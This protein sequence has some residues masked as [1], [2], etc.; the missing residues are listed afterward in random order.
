MNS[1]E[2]LISLYLT[3]CNEYQ[4]IIYPH[5]ERFTN[6][7]NISFTHE[8]VMAIYCY[9]I[10]RGYRTISVIHRYAQDNLSEH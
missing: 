3:I 4:N 2:K 7:K 1:K 6:A 8:E 10:L 5:A 9:G